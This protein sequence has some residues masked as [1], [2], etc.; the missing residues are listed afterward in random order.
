MTRPHKII[1]LFTALSKLLINVIE[2]HSKL[3]TLVP[4]SKLNNLSVLS[5]QIKSYLSENQISNKVSDSVCLA[6][7]KLIL[8]VVLKNSTMA[9]LDLLLNNSQVKSILIKHGLDQKID[10]LSVIHPIKKENIKTKHSLYLFS[11]K[12]KYVK[13]YLN[14]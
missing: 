8:I 12:N 5:S 11:M 3:G 2:F 1:I 4:I 14:Y 13:S 6:L 9:S 7:A 10:N